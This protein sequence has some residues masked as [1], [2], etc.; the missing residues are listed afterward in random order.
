MNQAF[1]FRSFL[2]GLDGENVFV[3]LMIYY[4]LVYF[5]TILAIEV[6][7]PANKG[8][9]EKLIL[10]KYHL[11]RQENRIFLFVDLK[12]S[13][14]LSKELTLENYSL[15][16]KEF[17]QDIDKAMEKFEGEIY[18]YAGDQVIVSWL[19]SSSN[20]DKAVRSFAEFY[21]QIKAKRSDYIQR[22]GVVPGFKAAIHCGVVIATWIGRMKR[23]L[24]FQGKVLN[25]AARVTG[26]AKNLN[27]PIL[28]TQEIAE[29][30]D[31]SLRKRVLEAG[32]YYLKGIDMPIN[33]YFLR[34]EER[35]KLAQKS[36]G[37]MKVISKN[38]TAMSEAI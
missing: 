28:L 1:Y 9:L 15:L 18:Q 21:N 2:P 23:E 4:T 26:L 5:I 19:A 22:Y 10:G 17:F 35:F 14:R 29:K 38:D 11:P 30:L 24:V 7:K 36:C 27:Y 6:S 12:E 20:Y 32:S 25:I 13:T 3:N 37:K 16:I 34:L 8:F 31:E 33:I